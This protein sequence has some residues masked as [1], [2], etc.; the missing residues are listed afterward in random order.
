MGQSLFFSA[1]FCEAIIVNHTVGG[2][3]MSSLWTCLSTS[4]TA[5][6]CFS[7]TFLS[8]VYFHPLL[9]LLSINHYALEALEACAAVLSSSCFGFLRQEQQLTD[10][11]S[12]IDGILFSAQKSLTT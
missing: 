6:Q 2:P 7:S 9:K 11:S 4:I 5:G 10:H 3:V 1:F 8:A 12:T